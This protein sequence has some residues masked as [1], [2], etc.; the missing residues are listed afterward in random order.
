[1]SDQSAEQVEDVGIDESIL[2]YNLHGGWGDEWGD[3]WAETYK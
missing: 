1:M 3:E 2:K